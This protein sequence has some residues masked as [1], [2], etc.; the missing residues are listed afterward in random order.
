MKIKILSLSVAV[1]LL[2]LFLLFRF[3]TNARENEY[4]E[5]IST[6]QS[7]IK[8]GEKATA[9]YDSVYTEFKHRGDTK[10][11]RIK[12]SFLVKG[13]VFN[14][15]KSINEAPKEPT[16]SIVYLPS[17]P[18]IHAEDPQGDFEYYNKNIEN[19]DSGVL[20]WSLF[21]GSILVFYCTR[22][23]HLNEV[24]QENFFD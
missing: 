1:F 17:N 14:D 22:R 6:A 9:V 20:A 10:S 15:E 7:L 4:D 18:D 21:I 19:K 2:S 16:F 13:K 3:Y 11:I 5:K 12:Y 8:S 24:R 23:S